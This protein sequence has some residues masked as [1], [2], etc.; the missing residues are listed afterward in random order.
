MKRTISVMVGK[1]SVRHNSRAFHA[2]N[3]DP[4]R[5]H[6][7]VTYCNEDIRQVYHELFD[8]A[9]ARYNEKQTRK[10]RCIADYYEKIRSGRQEKPFHRPVPGLT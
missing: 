1:G 3:T 2:A 9:I 8:E 7:N 4:A 6:L 5:S 10:D